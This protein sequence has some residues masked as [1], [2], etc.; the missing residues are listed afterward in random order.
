MT[1]ISSIARR[2]ARLSTR[3]S[4]RMETTATG[5]IISR[6]QQQ[7]P[8]EVRRPGQAGEHLQRLADQFAEERVQPIGHLIHVVRKAAHQVGRAVL[9]ERGQVH[10]QGATVEELP[11]VESAQLGQPHHEHVVG[12]QE[13]VLDQRPRHHQTGDQQQ[14]LEGALGQIPVDI[15]LHRPVRL[16]G[17][18][19]PI[20][21]GRGVGDGPFERPAGLGV[22]GRGD[23]QLPPQAGPARLRLLRH[24]RVGI[25][26]LPVDPLVHRLVL[27]D[28]LDDGIEDADVRD[29]EQ[30]PPSGAETGR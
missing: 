5:V 12:H 20:A 13:H 4:Q 29:P 16:Q 6:Q 7:P 26:D 22:A 11:Q 27:E 28:H 25:L 1:A 30:R 2:L 9:A 23:G 19:G 3:P 10:P 14:R 17:P 15:G 18:G 24:R 21:I 8:G